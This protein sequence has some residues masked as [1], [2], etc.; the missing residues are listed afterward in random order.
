MDVTLPCRR[1]PLVARRT[2]VAADAIN[3]YLSSTKKRSL[4]GE[5]GFNVHDR[6]AQSHLGTGAKIERSVQ[7]SRW[8]FYSERGRQKKPETR[9]EGALAFSIAA[10]LRISGLAD[11][12]NGMDV[13]RPI[14]RQVRPL[15]E[16]ERT[17]RI[18]SD[19]IYSCICRERSRT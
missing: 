12:T 17:G 6:T 11:E 8:H 15:F 19:G 1:C 7:T 16:F 14:S 10:R 5:C 13:R 3:D 18:P 4:F 2:Q 9:R